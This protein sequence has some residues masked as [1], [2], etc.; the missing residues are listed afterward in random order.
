MEQKLYI[1]SSK[2]I[3]VMDIKADLKWIHKELDTV[4]DP[5]LIE[6]FK[7]M[8]K[9]RNKLAPERITIE[10]YNQELEASEKEIESGSFYTHEDV[11]KIAGQWGKK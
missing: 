10:R 9:Y 11:K 5:T 6:A 3:N 1:Y 2:R 7:N 4:K 8:L